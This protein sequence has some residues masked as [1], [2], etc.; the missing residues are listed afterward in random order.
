MRA[1][2]REEG[3]RPG[4]LHG[5]RIRKKK[6]KNGPRGERPAEPKERKEDGRRVLGFSF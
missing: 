6:K 5:L 3:R 1:G 4:K 2:A